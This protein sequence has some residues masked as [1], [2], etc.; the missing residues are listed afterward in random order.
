MKELRDIIKSYK[1]AI[2]NH[3]Q[4]AL[5]TV[6]HIEGSSYR[7][8][9]A[10]MLITEDG[11]L[12][13]AISGGCLEG[14]ALRK[15][16]HVIATNNPSLVTYDTNDED[17]AKIGIGLGCNG[18]IQILI[19]PINS[20]DP[21]NPIAL[22]EALL[23]ER[24]SAVLTTL[25]SLDDR[26]SKVAGTRN[27]FRPDGNSIITTSD[28]KLVSVLRDESSA[29]LGNG[30]SRICSVKSN[31]KNNDKLET[32]FS[33]ISPPLSLI[34]IG[35]GNDVM[36]LVSISNTMGW[37]T[38]V[39]D[40]RSSYATANRFPEASCVM[41]LKP[42]DVLAE[43]SVDARTLFLLMT[44][45]YNYDLALLKQLLKTPTP[46]I[47]IL[48]PRKKTLRMLDEITSDGTQVSEEEKTKI[49][50][51]AGLDT[52]AEN[53]EEIALSICAE[54]NAVVNNRNG[55]SLRKKAEPI[56]AKPQK[57]IED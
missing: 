41:M 28:E 56:H 38:T 35:A 12:T 11:M 52:G 31:D 32:L 2:E 46:Y 5:A 9:G 53:S 50:G 18:I 48:G 3:K 8:P 54:I 30:L 7:Q 40:G 21:K 16:L 22:I 23:S 36:P 49:Y 13:G 44:H 17:D 57:L 51:P 24:V 19:E 14:D 33:L 34:I 45:N 4:T 55:T 10:R 1:K 43:I 20:A 15:A 39:I 26:K 25:F 27:L 47:G 42:T 37:E 29:V 6:V